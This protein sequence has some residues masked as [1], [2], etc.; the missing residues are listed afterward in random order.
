MS[1]PS[2]SES[3]VMARSNIQRSGRGRL[4]EREHFLNGAVPGN[5]NY[6]PLTLRK[7]D[8]SCERIPVN[9]VKR[10]LA[11]ILHN[12]EEETVAHRAGD[13]IL[14]GSERDVPSPLLKAFH[15]NCQELLRRNGVQP[16]IIATA[17]ACSVLD[18]VAFKF[19]Q[20]RQ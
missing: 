2:E 20:L 9:C 12:K 19:G 14:F 18:R 16:E 15:L 1:T 7:L 6:D 3:M 11:K 10:R 13:L 17:K 8:S 5:L 4:V